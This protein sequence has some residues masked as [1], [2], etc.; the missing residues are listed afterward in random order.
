M[1]QLGARTTHLGVP[2]I[3]TCGRT[4]LIAALCLSSSRLVLAQQ[5]GAVRPFR[6]SISDS[7]LNDLR[8]RIH[9]TRRR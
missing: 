2:T 7:A 6:S 4:L 5:D 9:D 3:R 1:M 8:K